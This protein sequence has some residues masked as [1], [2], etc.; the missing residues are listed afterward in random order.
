[1]KQILTFVS[2]THWFNDECVNL[3]KVQIDNSLE[4]GWSPED[5]ML[6]TNFEYEYNGVQSI[7][8]DGKSYCDFFPPATKLYTIVALFEQG[9][10]ED[11]LYW[12]HDFDCY[13]LN[14][15]TE[16][17]LG[18]DAY[19]MGLA[20]YGR[21]ERLCS[22]SMF[23][24]KT[25]GDIFASAKETLIKIKTDDEHAIMRVINDNMETFGKRAKLLNTTYAMHRFNLTTCYP[26]M[27]KP[28]KVAHFHPTADKFDFYTYGKNKLNMVFLPERLI[29][30]FQKYGY[31]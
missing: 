13:Q 22:A 21:R 30:I 19:D 9:L 26:D 5:I 7:V 17:E 24:K 3:V 1:M 10:I 23:F 6:V 12:Y 27:I 31:E 28:V 2:P 29:R 11:C 16:E 14:P 15:I 20:N 18:L 8:L 4:L 25:A